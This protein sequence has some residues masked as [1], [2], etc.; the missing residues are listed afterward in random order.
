[1]EQSVSDAVRSIHPSSTY[2]S[3]ECCAG[4]EREHGRLVVVRRRRGDEIWQQHNTWILTQ[5]YSVCLL[6]DSI[7]VVAY[8]TPTARVPGTGDHTAVDVGM[9]HVQL[10]S[11]VVL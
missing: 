1:M 2:T 4:C 10:H 3:T 7:S 9:N 11:A 6:A 5:S 8:T